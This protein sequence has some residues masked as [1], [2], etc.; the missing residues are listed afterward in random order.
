MWRVSD[1]IDESIEVS[2]YNGI[3]PVLAVAEMEEGNLAFGGDDSVITIWNWREN[4]VINKIFSHLGSTT[5]ISFCSPNFLFSTGGD[6]KIIIWQ[7]T[8]N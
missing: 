1:R 8:K 2:S 3:F 7:F 5:S 4:T 6:S